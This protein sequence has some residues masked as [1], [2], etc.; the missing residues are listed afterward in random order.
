M[1]YS[2]D[3][4]T[5]PRP[6]RDPDDRRPYAPLYRRSFTTSRF[7]NAAALARDV[8]TTKLRHRY[9]PRAVALTPGVMSDQALEAALLA[10]GDEARPAAD[11]A[12]VTL[13]W[14]AAGPR[15]LLVD[16]A[17]PLWRDRSEPRLEVVPGQDDPA[18][19]QVLPSRVTALEIVDASVT[20]VVDFFVRS[21]AGTRTFV[22]LRPI[23]SAVTLRLELHRPASTLFAIAEETA[24]L[25]ELPIDAQPPWEV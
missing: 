25:V 15:V 5:V 9:L 19:M 8:L 23:A 20:P 14:P 13:Y 3:V 18:Y 4:E 10:A 22:V 16:A 7:R 17:E 12:G 1:S 24:L 11:R 2:L 21:P 6:I